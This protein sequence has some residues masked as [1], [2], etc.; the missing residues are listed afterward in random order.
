[1]FWIQSRSFCFFLLEHVLFNCLNHSQNG[2]FEPSTVPTFR[3]LFGSLKTRGVEPALRL[4]TFE[5]IEKTF[6]HLKSF[7]Q[8]CTSIEVARSFGG[9]QI[10]ISHFQ[11]SIYSESTPIKS[12]WE[13]KGQI[14]GLV[15]FRTR[16]RGSWTLRAKHSWNLSWNLTWNLPTNLKRYPK[17]N[18]TPDCPIKQDLVFCLSSRRADV[19]QRTWDGSLTL[20]LTGK[21][22]DVKINKTANFAKR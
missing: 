3:S 15:I 1:M 21:N 19:C 6:H 13:I 11:N 7:T 8:S 9:D 20:W 14:K 18:I 4:K 10:E 16:S 2:C 12:W 17:L 5:V 22:E